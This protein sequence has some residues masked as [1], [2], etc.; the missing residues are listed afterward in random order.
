M[1]RRVLAAIADKNLG[2]IAFGPDDTASSG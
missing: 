1:S 2:Q